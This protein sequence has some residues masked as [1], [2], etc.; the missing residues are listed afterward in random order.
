MLHR[1]LVNAKLSNEKH[2]YAYWAKR[3]GIT[4]STITKWAAGFRRIS[5]SNIHVFRDLPFTAD[6]Y[7]ASATRSRS[8]RRPHAGR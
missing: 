8:R 1:F 6:E 7:Y 3:W 4:Y 5:T 2:D